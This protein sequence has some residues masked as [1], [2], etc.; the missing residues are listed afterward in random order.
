MEPSTVLTEM[1][2][3]MMTK[4]RDTTDVASLDI[5]NADVKKP[6]IKLTSLQLSTKAA[7][8]EN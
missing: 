6:N 1:Q 2:A 7:V 8:R 5:E 4:G 3:A